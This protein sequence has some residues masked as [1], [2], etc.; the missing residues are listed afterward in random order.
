MALSLD[1]LVPL[2]YPS[3]YRSSERG[4]VEQLVES[5]TLPLNLLEDR[6]AFNFDALAY[7]YAERGVD[8]GVYLLVT[9][10]S[11]DDCRA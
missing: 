9:S 11:S 7:G 3:L 2:S 1:E 4:A 10:L 8:E 6:A 5:A